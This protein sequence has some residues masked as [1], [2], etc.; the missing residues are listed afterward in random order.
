MKPIK[1][2]DYYEPEWKSFKQQLKDIYKGLKT[3]FWLA[4]LALLTFGAYAALEKAGW[5]SHRK[6]TD[7]LVDER[8]FLGEYRQCIT[9]ANSDGTIGALD[10]SAETKLTE[11]HFHTME[12]HY[13][14]RIKRPEFVPPLTR[15]KSTED[16]FDR[17]A[18]ATWLW[19]CQ[20]KSESITCW[21][22]N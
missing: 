20:R 1:T 14:G 19:R 3:L 18:R 9:T 7:I 13:W 5:I 21:A 8:W 10:C 22:V 2:G 15:P 17:I 11:T 6:T 4:F 12:I 16:I